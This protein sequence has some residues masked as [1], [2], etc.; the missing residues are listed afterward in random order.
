[1]HCLATVAAVF[2]KYS[3]KFQ[4][5]TELG[6]PPRNLCPLVS[7][8][9]PRSALSAPTVNSIVLGRLGWADHIRVPL[10]HSVELLPAFGYIF[11]L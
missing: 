8:D 11:F 3:V 5:K 2:R 6:S 4:I 7:S 9:F 1:M 10:T